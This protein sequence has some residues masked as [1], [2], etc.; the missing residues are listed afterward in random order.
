MSRAT[1]YNLEIKVDAETIHPM[2][3]AEFSEGDE[4]KIEVT[5]GNIKYK[6]RDQIYSI[7]E[8]EMEIYIHKDKRDYDVMQGWV[9]S[10]SP[11]DIH[12]IYR[13]GSGVAQLE[14]LFKGC[15]ISFGKKNAF[16]RNSKAADS[17][18][19]VLIPKEIVEV[20]I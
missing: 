14:F 12:I 13:D 2:T 16:D 6:I 9:K 11:K 19:Y 5:D 17:K 3:L 20:E 18:K 4:G 10:G 7:E 1:S 15:D 8:V